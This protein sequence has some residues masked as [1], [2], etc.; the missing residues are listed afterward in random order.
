MTGLTLAILLLAVAVTLLFVKRVT[1]PLAALAQATQEIDAGELDVRVQVQGQDEVGRLAASFNHMVERLK[2]YTGRLEEQTLELE[3]A[4]HQTRTVCGIVQKIGAMRSLSE[5]GPSLIKTFQD[6]LKC[7]QM[8]LLTLSNNRD[9]LF[10]SSESETRA[11]REL[12]PIESF[13]T[14]LEDITNLTFIKKGAFKPPLVPDSFQTA[15]R[16]AIIPLHHE[17]QLS[18]GL[19]IGCPGD[20]HC[21]VMEIDVVGLLLGQAAGVIKR[22][23]QQ[24]E[25]IREIQSRVESTAEFSGIIGKDPKM[26]L[27]YKLIEDIAPTDATGLIQGES[28]T[29]KELVARAIHRLSTRKNKPFVVINCSAYPATLL[30]SELFG[31]EKGAFTG[32]IRQKAGRFEQAHGGT[33]FLD[34]IGEIAPSAQI[35]LLRVLQTQKFERLGGEKTLTVDVRI[36]A[37][38]NKD[39]LQEVKKGLFREDLYYRLNVIPIQ[40]PPLLERRNDIPLLARH[41]LHRFA[42]EQGKKIEQFS[43]EALRLL[44][45]YSWPGNVRELENTVEHATVL[46]KGSRVEASDLPAALYSA[47]S[48]TDV[49]KPP[50]LVDHEKKLLQE[51]LEECGWNKKQAAKRLGISRSTLYE[52]LKKYQITQPTTH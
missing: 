5:I 30:E 2:E 12:E 43:P 22:A 32:A 1:H 50:T 39:L 23:V 18:G 4:H 41:F 9:L 21:N 40:L 48:A 17:K 26:Q 29:G 35:K 11:L 42:A 14:A 33:V 37:A 51:V 52:K 38:T 20:C 27:I 31:H 25:E 13:T 8:V 47:I 36:I 16:Q 28:G 6:I 3:R 46:A 19:V 15:V 34:E 49:G 45:D 7:G 44:L 10:V 24:E